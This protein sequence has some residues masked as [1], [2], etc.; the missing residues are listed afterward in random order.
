MKKKEETED[1]PKARTA[2]ETT[3]AKPRKSSVKAEEKVTETAEADTSNE[4]SGTNKNPIDK[5]TGKQVVIEVRDLHKSYGDNHVLQG[6]S[7]TVY[8]GEN[9]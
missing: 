3:A 7:L 1:A 8:K 9:L 5:K 6:L 4:T 2:K